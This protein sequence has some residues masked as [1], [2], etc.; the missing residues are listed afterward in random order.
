MEEPLHPTIDNE[1]RGAD[2]LPEPNVSFHHI[3]HDYPIF[4]D[5]IYWEFLI[6]TLGSFRHVLNGKE[7]VMKE[8]D[9][10]LIRPKDY[11]AVFDLVKPT[12]HLNIMISIPYMKM[13]CDQHSPK[14]YDELL[15]PDF[16]RATLSKR[17]IDK[18][19]DYCVM[20]KGGAS[21]GIDKSLVDTL[22]VGDILEEVVAQNMMI[23]TDRPS[24]LNEL[25][26][27]ITS[28]VHSA[29]HVHDVLENCAYSHTQLARLFK[30]YLGCNLAQYMSQVKMYTACDYLIHSD[31]SVLQIAMTLGYQS[32]TNFNAVFKSAIKMT[33]TQYRKTHKANSGYSLPRPQDIPAP[34]IAPEDMPPTSR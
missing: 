29:W 21:A 14:L 7:F 18:I 5:H 12:G 22:L 26:L 34:S 28:P 1:E 24:W 23:G 31:M 33:P 2:T 25:L 11:H 16:L 6:Q 4:H 32:V 27:Q 8:G 19:H 15:A 3:Y 10:F 30:K 17:D 20:L 13:I 9:A